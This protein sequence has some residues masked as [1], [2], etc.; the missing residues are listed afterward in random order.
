MQQIWLTANTD[1]FTKS[2]Q[3][4]QYYSINEIPRRAITLDGIMIAK[5]WASWDVK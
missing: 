2:L 4:S 3:I 5:Q 1:G